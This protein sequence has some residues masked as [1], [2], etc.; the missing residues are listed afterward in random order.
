MFF[1]WCI[2]SK[3]PDIADAT[4]TPSQASISPR[5]S[6]SMSKLVAR[7]GLTPLTNPQCTLI[8]SR[9]S[10]DSSLCLSEGYPPNSEPPNSF[11]LVSSCI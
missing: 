2:R 7:P 3:A 11:V 9:I 6:S 4:T 1:G 5:S 8:D 10:Y